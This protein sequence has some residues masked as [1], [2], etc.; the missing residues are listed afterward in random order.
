[1]GLDQTQARFT[2]TPWTL[3]GALRDGDDA[4]RRNAMDTLVG[5]YWPAVYGYLRRRGEDR[6]RAME[7]AQAFFADVVMGRSL[8]TKADPTRG[9]LRTLVL[10]ALQN[11]RRDAAR[12]RAREPQMPETAKDEIDRIEQ[13][14]HALG[15]SGPETEFHRQWAAAVLNEAVRRCREHFV[16]AGKLGHWD[17]FEARELAPL[18][19]SI[20]PRSLADLAVELGYR[21][22]PDAAAAIQTVKKR[23][24]ALLE[25][26]ICETVG[27]EDEGEEELRW[28][29]ASML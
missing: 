7:S 14:L 22:A 4:T 27:S 5:L 9:R 24:L 20:A 18:T 11:F 6:D 2:D 21:S 15:N 26:V 28:I 23:L 19:G 13:S 25:E 1:M 12:A 17:L 16:R 3:I 29:K 10:T 8:F